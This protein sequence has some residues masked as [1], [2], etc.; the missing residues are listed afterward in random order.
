MGIATLLKMLVDS[1][2]T[3]TPYNQAVCDGCGWSGE[4]RTGENRLQAACADAQVHNHESDVVEGGGSGR[5]LLY[6]F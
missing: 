2:S 1:L 6:R 5:E 3:N 4:R